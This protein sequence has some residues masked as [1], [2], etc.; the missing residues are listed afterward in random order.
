MVMTEHGVKCPTFLLLRVLEMLPV[1]NFLS[2]VSFIAEYILMYLIWLQFPSVAGALL[3]VTFGS[4]SSSKTG[5]K[6]HRIK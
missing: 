3:E 1:P 4:I 6:N 5:T 2:P